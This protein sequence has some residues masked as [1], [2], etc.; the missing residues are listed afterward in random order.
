MTDAA[1]IAAGLGRLADR[2]QKRRKPG[3]YRT[4]IAERAANM[5]HFSPG[6]T[7]DAPGAGRAA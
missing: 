5:R 6:N 1:R 3:L 2:L 7:G 4:E